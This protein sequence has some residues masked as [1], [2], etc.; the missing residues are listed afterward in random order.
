MTK[1]LCEPISSSTLSVAFGVCH[2]P[3]RAKES[4]LREERGR[5][6]AT[7]R[8]PEGGAIV[9]VAIVGI[10]ESRMLAVFAFLSHLF[11]GIT[12]NHP[13]SQPIE[14]HHGFN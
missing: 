6:S 4:H 9:W 10:F 12:S 3:V 7:S 2:D 5:L 11:A 14:G 8:D 13:S 1:P